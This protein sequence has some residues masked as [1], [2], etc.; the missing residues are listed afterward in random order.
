VSNNLTIDTC[1]IEFDGRN[2]TMTEQGAGKSI[3]CSYTNSSLS[4]G[5]TYVYK[6]YAN[7]SVDNLA[8]SGERNFTENS[9]PSTT[10]PTI[11]PSS[12]VTI[13]SLDC[14]ATLTDAEDTSP[15]VLAAYWNWYK[16]GVLYDSGIFVGVTS[17]EN[18]VINS[19][20]SGNTLKGE[21][22]SCSVKPSDGYENGTEQTSLNVTIQN[23]APTTP[24]TLDLNS[25]AVGKNLTANCYGSEDIDEDT[26]VYYYEF[27]NTDDN[28]IVQAWNTSSNYTVQ[29]SDAHDTIKITCGAFDGEA[30]SA[31]NITDT[32]VVA[33][34]IPTVST[35]TLTDP[36]NTTDD[37]VCSVSGW[38]DADLDAQQYYYEWRNG[39]T[40]VL[41]NL[42][43]STTD[44]LLAGNTTRGETWNC[45]VIPFDGIDNGS[46]MYDTTTIINTVPTT[47]TTLILNTPK[48][49]EIL[50]ATCSGS[51]DPDVDDGVDARTY[52]YEFSNINDS[53]IR[54]AWSTTSTYSVA[55]IDAHDSMNVTCGVFDGTAFSSANITNT[56][57]ILNTIPT[58]SQQLIF[59]NATT[60]HSFN[61]SARAND[62]DGI[63]DI[64]GTN[65]SSGSCALIS[66]TTISSEKEA[67][68]N[69][70]GTALQSVS[71]QISFNDSSSEYTTTSAASNTYPNQLSSITAV[72]V[73]PDT[74]YTNNDLTCNA[75]GASDSDGDAVSYW[76]N[77]TN[78]LT[79]LVYNDV[80]N[81]HVLKAGNTTKG[82]TWSCY[83][84]PTDT[85]QNG[86]ILSDS[87][88]ILNSIPTIGVPALNATAP[89]TNDIIRCNNG[90]FGDND[91]DTATWYYRWYDTGV[92]V[93]GQTASTLDLS[94]S[95][96][97]R[98][99][100]ITCSMIAS[101]GTVNATSWQ[102]SSNYA[103]INN[104]KP[105][106][107]SV[108]L[109]PNSSYTNDNLVCS[110]SG[111]SDTDLDAQQYYYEW[112]NGAT[113]VFTFLSSSTTNSLDAGNT[114]RSE[115]WNCTVIP[116][117]GEA[118]GTALSDTVTIQNT[119]PTMTS[120]SISP[121][122][123][124]DE[125]DLI[126]SAV[127]EDA[128]SDALIL[129]F[130]WYKNNAFLI[131]ELKAVAS[132]GTNTTTISSGSTEIGDS[133]NCTVFANDSNDLSAEK[134]DRK[135]ISEENIPGGGGGSI[136]IPVT[137]APSVSWVNIENGMILY[138]NNIKA[139]EENKAPDLW[140]I[141]LR[142]EKITFTDNFTSGQIKIV[143]SS[144][145]ANAPTLHVYQYYTVDTLLDYLVD[146]VTFG[147]R[148]PIKWIN[149]TGMKPQDI[150]LLAYDGVTWTEISME[151][152]LN[153][154]SYIEYTAVDKQL[155]SH[156]AI[157]G[158]Q[159]EPE[160]ASF[161]DI[162]YTI[163][164]Y[165]NGDATFIDVIN[166]LSSYYS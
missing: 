78:G 43:G 27:N 39:T 88:A 96:L 102:N 51:I 85:Y 49:G 87:V 41:T 59:S 166:A 19:L 4:D 1:I 67:V 165:Y 2:Y 21:N 64:V 109:G 91:S 122:S 75:T 90:S 116:F 123:P 145:P 100:N 163:E 143:E 112:R 71:I 113:L 133:W 25:P 152:G 6:I 81:T 15:E 24:T 160:R 30:Y 134:S 40:L 57:T 33:N 95:G 10:T 84:T 137:T 52:Y 70:T 23:S 53:V 103:I 105:G 16:N 111:W 147:Y 130:T 131:S 98:G 7:D 92:L 157:A 56:T 54:Q 8:V 74:A 28:I 68:Y 125:N 3:N 37:L 72:N 58:I 86:T 42:L 129:N 126:C 107:T 121:A 46:A 5:V 11:A 48:V 79:T 13:D 73:T 119:A 50:T 65:I 66:F 142:I 150:R 94:V 132:G 35:V 115:T 148:A 146:N 104:S 127:A 151:V 136:I 14:N 82:Q 61:V 114:T 108:D 22:W 144:A 135:L 154:E 120:V 80:S 34:T 69:C 140:P 44:T 38:S 155:Y 124:K 159:H 12:P 62:T 106:I 139:G 101:D 29:A 141:D 77:W 47:P 156:Y 162:L 99:D 83:V 32:T 128:D 31:A 45:T 26:I 36:A 110:A 138:F 118:N 60:G 55:V 17:G 76:Y 97:D 117:D 164:K 149:D 63:A 161:V 20:D 18:N 89:Y 158:V 9:V 93:S 153:N